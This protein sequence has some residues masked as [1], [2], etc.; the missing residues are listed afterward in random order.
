MAQQAMP[1]QSLN[2]QS[3]AP[4][5]PNIIIKLRA[6]SRKKV[7][8]NR[9]RHQNKKNRQAQ[10]DAKEE[11]DIQAMR[12]FMAEYGRMEFD[13][14]VEMK[15]DPR[16]PLVA[17]VPPT[18]KDGTPRVAE[19]VKNVETEPDVEGK[20]TV[21]HLPMSMHAS[22]PGEEMRE[23]PLRREIAMQTVPEEMPTKM[24]QE[25]PRL[26]SQKTIAVEPSKHCRRISVDVYEEE[27][28]VDRHTPLEFSCHCGVQPEPTN[29]YID[30]DWPALP[31]PGKNRFGKTIEPRKDQEKE[32]EQHIAKFKEYFPTVDR[33]DPTTVD[34]PETSQDNCSDGEDDGPGLV[35][36]S[37]ED[38]ATKIA[39]VKRLR[40]RRMKSR[41]KESR[42]HADAGEATSE[43]ESDSESLVG[44]DAN[45]ESADI[46][47]HGSDEP[48][49]GKEAIRDSHHNIDYELIGEAYPHGDVESRTEESGGFEAAAGPES[50]HERPFGDEDI[51]K[52]RK[53]DEPRGRSIEEILEAIRQG[54]D[55]GP[56]DFVMQKDQR[57]ALNARRA[58]MEHPVP[59]RES[60]RDIM[61]FMRTTVESAEAADLEWGEPPF[62]DWI[63]PMSN[64]M[65]CSIEDTCKSRVV[66][67]ETNKDDVELDTPER[68]DKKVQFVTALHDEGKGMH[69]FGIIC[70]KF[71]GPPKQLS[72][73]TK[74][75]S[76]QISSVRTQDWV[77]IGIIV[78]SGA[79]DTVMPI[80]MCGHILVIS[81]PE[82]RAGLEYEVANGASIPNVGE[83]HCLVMTEDSQTMNKLIFQ[84][85]DVHKALLSVA[86]VADMG[87]ECLLVE[88]GGI[89]R[90]VASGGSIPLHRRGNL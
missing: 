1:Q 27:V 3:L 76:S 51:G 4:R 31:A 64:M 53:K 65:G 81:T 54:F 69:D 8:C 47:S 89:L 62:H 45:P 17:H 55:K 67:P 49:C 18:S 88:E 78:D 44:G 35:D 90:D 72:V 11:D 71:I 82:S 79:C 41:M 63:S 73:M 43:E 42:K 19:I 24:N 30:Q 56:K 86:N 70:S 68:L 20:A 50:N 22:M 40:K 33:I 36:G 84:C 21:Q 39:K 58:K 37:N 16:V 12:E 9:V 14:E 59:G 87:F 10:I 26:I 85:A 75:P 2:I 13:V 48:S 77:E 57:K 38:E 66:T 7:E 5:D 83:R 25:D 28:K 15:V 34:Y 6:L 23:E 46:E 74:N 61:E 80:S 52:S 29:K 32:E 60:K